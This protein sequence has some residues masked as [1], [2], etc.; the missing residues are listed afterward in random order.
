MKKIILILL[1]LIILGFA[2]VQYNDP[3]AWFWIAVYLVYAM[4]IFS[5]IIRPLNTIWYL[6]AMIVPLIFAYFQWPESWEG[7]GETMMNE[8][9]E[10]ARESLGLIICALSSWL[11]VKLKSE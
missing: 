10:R 4:V 3:D 5:A 11:S 1:F 8:N 7:I 2:A 9:T 6:V